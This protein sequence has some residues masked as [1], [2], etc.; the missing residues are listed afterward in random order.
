MINRRPPRRAAAAALALAATL[1][2]AACGSDDADPT[3]T[4]PTAGRAVELTP[5]K[6]YLL[7]HTA[8]LERATA[9][10]RADA[11]AYHGLAEAAGFDYAALLADRRGEV[12]RLVAGLQQDFHA[13]NPAYEEMEGVVAGVPSLAD[14]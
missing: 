5:V 10:I 11:E 1:A 8:R 7:D 12:R 9:K 3:A 14:F 2:L 4:S 6:D 13:A